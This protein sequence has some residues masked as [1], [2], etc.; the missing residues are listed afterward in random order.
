MGSEAC[1]DHTT[2]CR[3]GQILIREGLALLT[4]G[5][6]DADDLACDIGQSLSSCLSPDEVRAV[7]RMF[8]TKAHA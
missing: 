3:L 6:F 4:E 7:A 5:E 1:V 8:C 2:Q